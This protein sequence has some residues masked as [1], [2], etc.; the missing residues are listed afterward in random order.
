MSVDL[1]MG[2]LPAIL[3]FLISKYGMSYTQVAGLMFG[4]TFL[5]SFLQPF[6]GYMADK[7]SKHWFIGAGIL[8][9]SFSFSIVGLTDDYTTIFIAVMIMGMGSSIFHPEGAKIINLIS[10]ENKGSGMA[11]FSI[12]GNAGFGIGPILAIGLI[13]LFDL[14]GIVL[15]S[16]IGLLIGLPAIYLIPKLMT[17]ISRTKSSINKQIKNNTSA[18][19]DWRAFSKLTIVLMCRSIIFYGFTAFL[20]L[21]CISKLNISNETAGMLLS[22]YA[23]VGV[24]M[25]M[26]GGRLA[27]KFELVNV[28]KICSLFYVPSILLIIFAP[29]FWWTA[30]LI[31]P[32]AFATHSSYSPFV[33]LG[34]TYLSKNIGLASGFTLGLSTSFGGIFSPLIGR[35][36]DNFGIEFA[37]YIL[38]AVGF[39]CTI[40]AFLLPRT[41]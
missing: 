34:Q 6:F 2:A 18:K 36:A 40:G 4:A 1:A 32:L 7:V 37:M 24:C 26:L 14:K 39:L 20:P 16:C 25:T 12:G 41:R 30:F 9:S 33:L 5:S 23:I 29:N 21:F 17:S 31:L 19:N 8:L 27:D 13:T 10:G 28:I 35:C 11:I 22:I 3:P 38:V 15:F